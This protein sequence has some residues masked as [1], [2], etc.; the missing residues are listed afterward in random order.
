ME[1]NKANV[2]VTQEWHRSANDGG[3]P[4]DVRSLHQTIQEQQVTD[5]II[6][7]QIKLFK[8]RALLD[9]FALDVVGVGS[10][11]GL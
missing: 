11:I 7:A 8:Q 10:V 1:I 9:G 4:D 3:V 6:A 5:D 2:C